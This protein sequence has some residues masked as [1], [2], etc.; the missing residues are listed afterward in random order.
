[1]PSSIFTVRILDGIYRF[2]SGLGTPVAHVWFSHSLIEGQS[3]TYIIHGCPD[4]AKNL[5]LSYVEQRN[6]ILM[7]PLS[8]DAILAEH[9]LHEW[10]QAVYSPRNHLITYVRPYIS[11]KISRSGQI[12]LTRKIP[13]S[14]N[15]HPLKLQKRSRD[16]IPSPSFF[17]SFVKRSLISK[18]GSSISRGST[19][20]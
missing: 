6:L 14:H 10:G 12:P 9:S 5:I 1:M 13:Q 11:H 17:T 18:S 7:R 16:C 19:N 15:L 4:M 20:A 3:S 2:S 8:V